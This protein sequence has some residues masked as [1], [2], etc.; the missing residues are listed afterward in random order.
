MEL[1]SKAA[2]PGAL[3]L[4]VGLALARLVVHCATNGQYGFHRDELAVLDD[5]RHLAWGY[6]AYPPL[7][8]AVAWLAHS[9]FGPSLVG[10]RFFSALAQCA[11]MVVAGLIAYELGGSRQA[12]VV[13]ALAVAIAPMSLIMGALFQYIALDYWWW[14]LCAYLLVRLIKTGDARGWLAVGAVIGLGMLTKYTMLVFVAG[15]VVAVLATPL[16]RHLRSGWLWAGA[17]LSLVVF[18]PN[19]LWQI[20]N[21]WIGLAFTSAIH[22]RDLAVGRADGYFTQQ[23][24]ANA[25]PLTLPLWL[26]GL[27]Y[28]F[29]APAG[30]P[31]RALG[32]LYLVPLVVFAALQGRFY[33]LAPAYVWLLAGGVVQVEQWLSRLA[34]R[35]R[36]LAWGGLGAALATGAVVGGA[37]MLP[38]AP[39]GSAWFNTAGEVHDNF[40]EQVGWPELVAAVAEIYAA[41]PV[42]VQARTGLLVSNYGEA[43]AINLYGPALGLPAALSGVNS[44]WHRGYGSPPPERLIVLGFSEERARALFEACTLAGQVTNAAGVENEETR[45]H[46]DIFVCSGPRAPW[47]ELWD[48]LRAFA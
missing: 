16:R 37:L 12:Q 11:A 45:F 42:D 13:T 44:Y 36:R 7:T 28:F 18:L 41:Q 10:L 25:N 47:P 39:V 31:Y 20:Q 17:A 43:G 23:L 2:P 27:W 29:F 46:S 30:R 24:V 5:A 48:S 26:I 21:D 1:Q 15:L 3:G 9:L 34:H 35:A 19:L 4:L 22:A 14:V 8:P 6:V 32:W 38:I 40:A 33:Y